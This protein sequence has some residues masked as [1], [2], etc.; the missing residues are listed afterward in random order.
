MMIY[1]TIFRGLACLATLICITEAQASQH[2][3]K[4]DIE[5]CGDRDLQP[6]AVQT[7]VLA[8][9]CGRL[10][11][12]LR[13]NGLN[14]DRHKYASNLN[15]N[16]RLFWGVDNIEPKFWTRVDAATDTA[17]DELA[18]ALDRA[19]ND[20]E[21]DQAW[22]DFNATDAIGA[23]QGY[24]QASRDVLK[25]ANTSLLHVGDRLSGRPQPLELPT[26][27]HGRSFIKTKFAAD[28]SH[29][30][31]SVMTVAGLTRG[32]YQAAFIHRTSSSEY[33]HFT[34]KDSDD[35][36]EG[37]SAR[38]TNAHI[39]GAQPAL[40]LCGNKFFE[41]AKELTYQRYESPN[42]DRLDTPEYWAAVLIR[43][44]VAIVVP[45]CK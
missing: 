14:F 17:D 39:Y 7:F 3:F 8:T 10:L 24:R 9:R 13:V 26:F 19:Q 20:Q 2:T 30:Q 40:I 31:P 4:A 21:R 1:T 23:N 42:W 41:E 33:I 44:L 43:E 29:E 32:T 36:C 35:V 12:R 22:A 16:A 5:T 28:V 27:C 37:G 6:Y 18:A 34:L 25:A 45:G 11:N 15:Y 38:L